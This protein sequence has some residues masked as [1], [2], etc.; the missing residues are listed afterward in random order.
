MENFVESEF[1]NSNS[2]DIENQNVGTLN[3]VFKSP[4]TL[5]ISVKPSQEVT[6]RHQRG[7]DGE[8]SEGT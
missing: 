2:L 3:N 6:G 1:S 5:L 4:R 7:F 8:G